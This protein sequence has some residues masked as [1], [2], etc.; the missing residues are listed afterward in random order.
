MGLIW[1]SALRQSSGGLGCAVPGHGTCRLSTDN[2]NNAEV[3]LAELVKE[4]HSCICN[5][6]PHF[7]LLCVC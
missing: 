3:G 7:Q 2:A 6:L 5:A 4:D 1:S